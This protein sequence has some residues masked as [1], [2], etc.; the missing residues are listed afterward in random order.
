MSREMLLWSAHHLLCM[1]RK[2]KRRLRD[3]RWHWD[4][5]K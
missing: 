1:G 4:K 3:H 2:I 5:S